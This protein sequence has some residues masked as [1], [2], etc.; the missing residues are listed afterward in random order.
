MS[1]DEKIPDWS[2]EDVKS[3]TRTLSLLAFL[4]YMKKHSMVLCDAVSPLQT[5]T[6]LT[7]DSM[8]RGIMCVL[9]SRHQ[10]SGKV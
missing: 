1:P 5:V 10:S 2:L 3:Q 4:Y 7:S 9:C 6:R 8:V